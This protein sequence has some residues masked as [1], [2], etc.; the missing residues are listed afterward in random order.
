MKLAIVVAAALVATAQAQ[1]QA[2]DVQCEA[3]LT[4]LSSGMNS[5][6]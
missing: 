6:W 3:Q 1:L 5:A 2:S 4:S